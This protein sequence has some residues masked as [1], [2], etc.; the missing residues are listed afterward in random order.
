MITTIM[1]LAFLGALGTL[2]GK[3][4]VAV[5]FTA[6]AGALAVALHLVP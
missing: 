2:E 1:I 5:A 6:I 3:P 4:K